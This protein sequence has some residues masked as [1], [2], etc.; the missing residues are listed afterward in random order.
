M[1]YKQLLNLYIPLVDFIADIIGPHCEVLLHD[2]VDVENSVIAIRNGY[3]SGRHIGCPLTDLGF[4]LLENKSYLKQNQNALVNYRSR[5][6]SG[7]NLIS[8]TY[9]IKDEKGEL[10]GMICV[11]I[12]NSTDHQINKIPAVFPIT[13]IFSNAVH[14]D[15]NEEITESLSTSLDNVVDE[16]VKK[17]VEK[18][19][20]SAD[21]MSTEEKCALVQELRENGIF[22]IKGAITKV[23]NTLKTSES[24]IY[25]YL[26]TK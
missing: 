1:E 2:I 14:M 25:R 3:I 22:K 18:Y 17:L 5:T 12:L 10:I 15:D 24:T 6:D 13:A 8:S 19:D 20:I 9:Y 4:K 26:A 11:N 21:R 7:E 23:A 16:A